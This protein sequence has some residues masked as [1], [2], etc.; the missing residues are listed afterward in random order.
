MTTP[1][2]DTTGAGVANAAQT[3]SLDAPAATGF[4]F[5]SELGLNTQAE[6]G[7]V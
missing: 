3:P 6:M 1:K 4:V 2:S 7:A 5:D